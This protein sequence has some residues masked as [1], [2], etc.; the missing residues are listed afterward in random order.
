MTCVL[1]VMAVLAYYFMWYY[2]AILARQCRIPILI[3][4]WLPNLLSLVIGIALLVRSTRV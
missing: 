4:C 2:G 3:G 1:T